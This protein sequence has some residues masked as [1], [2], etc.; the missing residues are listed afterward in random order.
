MLY[1]HDNN[2]DDVQLLRSISS[3]TKLKRLKLQPTKE[4]SC[5]QTIAYIETVDLTKPC[6]SNHDRLRCVL[7]RHV[8]DSIDGCT[9]AKANH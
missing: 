7:G 1:Y 3:H 4:D 6:I 9:K 2:P 5:R 8:L